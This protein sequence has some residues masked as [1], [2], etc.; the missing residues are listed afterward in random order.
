[1]EVGKSVT[2]TDEEKSKLILTLCDQVDASESA[3]ERVKDR[4]ESVQHIYNCDD[5]SSTLNI[6][7]ASTEVILPSV[8]MVL[9][10]SRSA[11]P[12]F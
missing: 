3:K 4:W 9:S 10:R 8:S 11:G 6:V 1:M 5:Q 2:L 7:P 12:C